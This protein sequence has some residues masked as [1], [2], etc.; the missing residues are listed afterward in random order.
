LNDE[1]GHPERGR[2]RR[3]LEN[4]KERARQVGNLV[5]SSFQRSCQH[6]A[7]KPIRQQA[8]SNQAVSTV[9]SAELTAR[10]LL[11][12]AELLSIV[13]AFAGRRIPAIVL[14]GIP[15]TRR[16][17]DRLDGREVADNDVMVRK[18][19]CAHAVG[20]LT[21]LGYESIDC[22]TI[23]RQVDVDFQFRMVRRLGAESVLAELH[24][25][26]FPQDLYPVA[27]DLLWSRTERFALRGREV[28]VFDR[29]LTILHL[30]AHFAQHCFAEPKILR[31]L[32][33]A[34][35]RW[36]H[37]TDSAE[38]VALARRTR[39]IH[40]LDYALRSA[41]ALGMLDSAP[42]QVCSLRAS[43]LLRLLPPQRLNR[44]LEQVP[45]SRMVLALL[46]A[47]VGRIPLWGWKLLFPSLENLAVI[48]DRPVSRHLY[49]RYLTR[50]FRPVARL[51]RM[52]GSQR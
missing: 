4:E 27:E 21:E 23:E 41:A 46:L 17:F 49:L 11:L 25:N 6:R 37:D 32:A 28:L 47:P 19:D 34:W 36:G 5:Q 35:N 13:S 18:A 3:R 9:T 20:A 33:W 14:K 52:L 7:S 16:L 1:Q 26:A 29:P 50:P 38:L 48:H 43:A 15:L 44:P 42:P 8:A 39:L 31:D 2:G 30:A 22:R 10:N 12:E 24:W 51:S 40:A 45:Y